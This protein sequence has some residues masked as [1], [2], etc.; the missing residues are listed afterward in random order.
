[1]LVALT[2]TTVVAAAPPTV[3]VAPATKPVPVRVTAVPPAVGPLLGAIDISVGG[4]TYVNP[5]ASVALWPSELVITTAAGPALP[6][7][8][9]AVMLVA[10]TTTTAVAGMPPTV[11]VAPALK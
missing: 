9:L 6:A 11:T 3:T 4:A 5:A 8:V 2:T 10:L 7:G 1:M